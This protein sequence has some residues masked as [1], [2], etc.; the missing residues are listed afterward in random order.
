[1]DLA[2]AVIGL[3]KLTACPCVIGYEF[4]LAVPLSSAAASSMEFIIARISGDDLWMFD[5]CRS[6]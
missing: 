6:R 5:R 4:K 3:P 1:M 2:V